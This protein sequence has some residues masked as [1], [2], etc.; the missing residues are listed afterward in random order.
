MRAKLGSAAKKNRRYH[1]IDREEHDDSDD[2]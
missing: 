1:C 2:T